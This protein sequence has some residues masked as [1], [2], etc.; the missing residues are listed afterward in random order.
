MSFVYETIIMFILGY[1]ILVLPIAKKITDETSRKNTKKMAMITTIIISI[2]CASVEGE[3]PIVSGLILIAVVRAIWSATLKRNPNPMSATPIINNNTNQTNNLVC[4]SCGH[5]TNPGEKFC[6]SCGVE[7]KVETITQKTGIQEAV[8]AQPTDYEPDQTLTLEGYIEKRIKK[9]MDKAGIDPKGK[10][11]PNQVLKRFNILNIIFSVLLCFYISLIFFHFP[12]ITYIVGL[13]ILVVLFIFTMKFNFMKYITKQ[14]KSRPSEKISN[15]IMS[16][17]ATLVKNT[18]KSYLLIGCMIAICIPLVVFKNPKIFYEKMDNGYGVRF[19]AFGLTNNTT[20]TIPSTHKGKNVISLRGNTFSN[21]KNLTEIN[22]PNTITEIRGQA[23]AGL[24]KL[25]KINL[26]ENLE[27]LGGGAFKD[28]T[29]LR[30][31]VIPSKIKEINGDTFNNAYSL[32]SVTLPNGLERIGGSAFENCSNLEYI[33]LPSTLKKIGGSAFKYSALKEINLP[34]GLEVIDGGAF[35]SCDNLTEIIMPD[36]VTTLGGEAFQFDRSIK[37]VKLS[38]NLTEIRGNTFEEC[39][40]L[41]TITIPNNVTRI[42][43]HA[44]YG[45]GLESVIINKGS[46]LREIGSSA[47]RNCYDLESITLPRNVSINERA[48][49]NS[50]TQIY[51]FN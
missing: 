38:N 17:K 15:I 37:N 13:I 4:P 41:K 51:Y 30:T 49:K 19:Y 39:Y 35:A 26:P 20:A 1:F 50:P 44:F 45:S 27:Y 29:S 11:V 2:L 46:K 10:M 22:L 16:T 33:E 6:T 5:I 24:T 40:S 42:G 28:C 34:E 12:T 25:E 36:S 21:M 18:S 31:I 48:F 9:E 47:F 23:F 3:L 32:I 7:L 14:V 43:G 8:Y